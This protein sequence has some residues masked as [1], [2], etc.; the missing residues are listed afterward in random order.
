MKMST[1]MRVSIEVDVTDATSQ[2]EARES[3]FDLVKPLLNSKKG[4]KPSGPRA[5]VTGITVETSGEPTRYMSPA[6]CEFTREEIEA[7]RKKMN[8]ETIETDDDSVEVSRTF[9]S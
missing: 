8:N 3:A 6:Q 1:K 5:A 9:K 7:E 2:S 4:R